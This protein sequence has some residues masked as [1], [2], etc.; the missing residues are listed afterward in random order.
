MS[1][2]STETA[3]GRVDPREMFTRSTANPILTAEHFPKMVNSVFNPAAT[4]FQDETLLLVRLEDRTGRSTL[5]VATSKN[6]VDKWNIDWGRQ[7]APELDSFNERWGVEDPRITLVGDDY[8]VVYTGF[9]VGGP[10][11]CLARTRDFVE[12]ERLGVVQA[13]EDKDAALFPRTFDGRWALIHRPAPASPG[14]GAHIWLSRSPDLRH[15][16][17]G[18]I[19]LH[20]RRGGWWDANKIGLGPPPLETQHGWLI[21]YHGV[22][23][24]ASGSIYRLGL[25][26]LDI[27]DP[28]KVL[29][30]GDEWVF[31]PA[32]HYERSGDVPDVVFPCGWI[33]ED[34]GDT[35]QMYYGAADT[36]VCLATAS[37]AELIAQLQSHNSERH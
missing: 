6:G 19:L 14:L 15:W 27:D 16:G 20:A 21:C 12:F 24:T 37:L 13:P 18:Q 34:D 4:R 30:R 3:V 28:C 8:Y 2:A 33:L 5:V 23:T 17:A 32:A 1:A 7:L 11:V 22:R 25:A 26:M 31:G 36:S 29:M 35:L 9:G 10:M